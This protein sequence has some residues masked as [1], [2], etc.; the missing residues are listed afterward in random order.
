M[1]EQAAVA[2]CCFSRP[3]SRGAGLNEQLELVSMLKRDACV[4][5]TVPQCWPKKRFLTVQ[6][7]WVLAGM[8][9]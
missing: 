1:R 6:Q 3:N 2:E 8:R 5:Y 7:A 9:G 4:S